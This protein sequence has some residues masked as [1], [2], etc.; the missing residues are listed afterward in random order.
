MNKQIFNDNNNIAILAQSSHENLFG[1]CSRGNDPW[2]PHTGFVIEGYE[3]QSMI[4]MIYPLYR[5]VFKRIEANGGLIDYCGSAEVLKLEFWKDEL[6]R[7]SIFVK[8]DLII[9]SKRLYCNI[10]K[11]KRF[12]LM[13]KKGIII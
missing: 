7:P 12:A 9:M 6:L 13:V 2:P 4:S 1:V 8:D 3:I 5:M 11:I 10:G